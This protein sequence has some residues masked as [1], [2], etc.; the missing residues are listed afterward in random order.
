MGNVTLLKFKQIA[1]NNLQMIKKTSP[2]GLTTIKGL[3]NF[4][5]K[6]RLN[7]DNLVTD[8]V[9]MVARNNKSYV[10]IKDKNQAFVYPSQK[11]ALYTAF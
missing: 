5:S 4:V 7:W 8:L 11:I 2:I 9:K 6:G 3:F 10:E 1:L